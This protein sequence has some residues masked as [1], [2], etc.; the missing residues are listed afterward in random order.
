MSKPLLIGM[1]N[2][3]SQRD[4][5]ALYPAPEGCTGH[6]LW[7]MLNSRTGASR[8]QYLECFDRRNLVTGREWDRLAARA[9]AYEMVCELRDSGRTVVLL[10]NSVR[11]AFHFVLTD[12]EIEDHERGLAATYKGGLPPLLVHPQVAG[13]CT[14]RQIPHPSGRNKWYDVQENRKVVELLMEELYEAHRG[15]ADVPANAGRV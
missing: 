7:A 4:G 12:V 6:R 9:R 2:P 8:L 10:G 3:L 14:W 1:N 15:K 11:E 5:H 13:G